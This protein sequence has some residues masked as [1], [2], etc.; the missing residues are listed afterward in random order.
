MICDDVAQAFMHSFQSL[1][2][3]VEIVLSFL[4]LC[5]CLKVA[6]YAKAGK[7]E[8]VAYLLSIEGVSPDGEKVKCLTIIILFHISLRVKYYIRICIVWAT[9]KAAV[10]CINFNIHAGLFFSIDGCLKIWSCQVCDLS[11]GER[12]RY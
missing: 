3:K 1:V 11:F 7:D 6:C 9:L 5:Y 10:S 8:I 12:C 2:V 4:G